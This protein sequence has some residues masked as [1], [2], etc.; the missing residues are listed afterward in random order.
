MLRIVDFT[1][2]YQA[3]LDPDKIDADG[4]II[5]VSEGLSGGSA[6]GWQ[7]P[8]NST[9]IKNGSKVLGLYHYAHLDSNSAITEANYFYNK[10][11]S[12]VGKAVF[13][14]DFESGSLA[15]GV[16]KAKA[17]LDEFKRLSGVRPLLYTSKSVVRQYDWT[18]V[19]KEYAL[20]GAQ[21][22]NYNPTGWLTTPWTDNGG[23]GAFGD[24]A[25]F[26]YTS[27][28]RINGYGGN[29]DL[30]LFY[31]NKETWKQFATPHGIPFVE[32]P[33]HLNWKS[34]IDTFKASGDKFIL[35]KPFTV[36]KIVTY[37]GIHQ[38]I[39]EKLAGGKGWSAKLNGI[40]EA[41]L[42]G[43][44][45]T[46]KFKKAWSTGT[47]DAYDIKSNGVGIKFGQYGMIWFNADALLAL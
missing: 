29:V 27:S 30:S 24:P 17:F 47:I 15:G 32:T 9:S 39:S 16:A 3:T 1:T 36:D 23:W 22:A 20:W 33:A 25:I 6:D 40:P 31:G 13:F 10:V 21:Y 41:L 26:Q 14:L 44:G 34:A 46:R 28:G 45:K 11:K 8:A 42:E 5:K 37:A 18:P 35:T 12:Y 19:A 43:T 7:I 38:V 2:H 4:V